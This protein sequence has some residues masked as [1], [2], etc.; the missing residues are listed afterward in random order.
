MTYTLS[1]TCAKHLCK[2]TLLVQLIIKNVVTCFFGTQCR[3]QTLALF[4][5]YLALFRKAA[6][7]TIE[8]EQELVCDLSNDTI[9]NDLK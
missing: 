9:F 1:N 5:Q 2:R 6:I 7:V 4:D 3:Y 8:D